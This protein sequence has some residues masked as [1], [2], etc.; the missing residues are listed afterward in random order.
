MDGVAVVDFGTL[1]ASCVA[2]P[3]VFTIRNTGGSV[4]TGLAVTKDGVNS[5]AFTVDTTAMTITLAPGQSTTF[6]ATFG[7]ATTAA[8]TAMIHIASND[9]DENPF[10]I[11]LTGTAFSATQDSDGDGLN[12]WAEYQ[13]AALGFNWQVS[14]PAL[15]NTLLIN[16]NTAGLYTAAQLQALNVGTP[17]IGF[18]P[19]TGKFTLTIGVMKSTDLVHFQPFPFTPPGLKINT[20]GQIEYQFL[21]PDNT[22]FFRLEAH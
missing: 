5:N 16:A 1:Q 8:A 21:P 2:A 19:T 10:D 22:A 15:V 3:K 6:S 9:P 11:A 7:C 4:L 13:L 12:D 17:L 18:D 14:Q 20:Q